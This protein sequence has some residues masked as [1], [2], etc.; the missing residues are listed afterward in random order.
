[1]ITPD[2]A[3]VSFRLSGNVTELAT[4]PVL[5]LVAGMKKVSTMVDIF[6]RNARPAW[7]RNQAVTLP[8]DRISDHYRG[9]LCASN[10]ARW[11]TAVTQ[12]PA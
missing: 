5:R 10:R 1:M 3:A 11:Q 12:H 4:L 7:P 9:R 8:L 6:G 2:S